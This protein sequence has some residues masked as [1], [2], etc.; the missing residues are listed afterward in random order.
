MSAERTNGGMMITLERQAI[1]QFVVDQMFAPQSLTAFSND[2]L[3]AATTTTGDDHVLQQ[4]IAIGGVL[5]IQLQFEDLKK[6]ID[7]CL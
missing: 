2:T 3:L 1:D 5:H 7:V 4:I 6:T